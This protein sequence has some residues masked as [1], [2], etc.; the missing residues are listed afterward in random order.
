V[1]RKTTKSEDNINQPYL[2]KKAKKRKRRAE[3]LL[4]YHRCSKNAAYMKK[5]ERKHGEPEALIPSDQVS[6]LRPQS[7]ATASV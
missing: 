6:R 5:P 7:I 2:C 4:N 3:K 1:I